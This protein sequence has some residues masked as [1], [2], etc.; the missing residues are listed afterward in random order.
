MKIYID[1]EFKCHTT[2]PNNNYQA[3]ETEFFDGKCDIFINGY[4]YDDSRGYT[5][6]YP[7]KPYYELDTAQRACER[8]QLAEADEKLAEYENNQFELN[9]AYIEGVNSI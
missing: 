9:N 3:V 5:Q 6:I 8:Q 4:C 1:S 7:W 2:N